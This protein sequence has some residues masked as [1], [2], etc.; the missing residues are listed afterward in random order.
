MATI[1]GCEDC[2]VSACRRFVRLRSGFVRPLFVVS[3]CGRRRVCGGARGAGAII[4]NQSLVGAAGAAGAASGCSLVQPHP[5][6][7][8][9]L[10]FARASAR[11]FAARR[12]A[13]RRGLVTPA[14]WAQ[15]WQ[16]TGWQAGR[17]ARY[18]CRCRVRCPVAARAAGV[19]CAGRVRLG[20]VASV[21]RSVLAL[22]IAVVIPV[23]E[24]ALACCR[25][26]PTCGCTAV[27]P[28]NPEGPLGA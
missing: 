10:A 7:S 9:A 4:A 28:G 12:L 23:P 13:A 11:A 14:G 24:A 27:S 19:G 17:V 8:S 21:R 6:G 3:P 5:L 20:R 1:A 18:G 25:P 26:R 22:A 15:G 16:A 2:V